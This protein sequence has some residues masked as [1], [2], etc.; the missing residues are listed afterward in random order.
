MKKTTGKAFMILLAAVLLL[1]S[2]ACGA[3]ESADVPA[4]PETADAAENV[5]E[6]VTEDPAEAGSDEAQGPEETLEETEGEAAAEPS[7]EP[8]TGSGVLV[9]YFS[10]TGTTRGVAEMIAEIEGADLYEI[11]PAREYT[12]DDLNWHDSSSRTT[13]EQNDSEARPEMAGDPLSLEGYA[14]VYLGYPIW[15][16]EE[17]RI[18][19]TFVEAYSFEGVTVIPFCTS[20]SS[21]IGRSGT[22]LEENAGSGIWLEGRRFGGDVTEEELRS[23]IEG[24]R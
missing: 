18:L 21:G 12:E 2:A 4:R 5:T 16:G 24:L 13:L 19:D 9:A 1:G 6:N 23:W 15:W 7:S 10:A 14:T 3:P 20:S 22:N 17:P 8:E 11:L